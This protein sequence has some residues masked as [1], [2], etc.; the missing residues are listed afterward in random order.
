MSVSS[1]SWRSDT[2]ATS[3]ALADAMIELQHSDTPEGAPGYLVT[4]V[5]GWPVS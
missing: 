3:T 5:T 1:V 2:A 4:K